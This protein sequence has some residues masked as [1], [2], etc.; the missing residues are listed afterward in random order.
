MNE[1]ESN[2]LKNGERLFTA[3]AEHLKPILLV[4]YHLGM[5][6]G[7]ILSLKRFAV[8]C[9]TNW[10]RFRSRSRTARSWAIAMLLAALGVLSAIAWRRGE[11]SGSL[12]VLLAR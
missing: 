2:L 4:A 3:A 9:R 12:A 7:E 5:R 10:L 1:T 11:R 6:Q 8:L